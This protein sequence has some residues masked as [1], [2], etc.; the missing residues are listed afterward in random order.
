MGEWYKYQPTNPNHPCTNCQAG[1][2]SASSKIQDGE[3]WVK[4][5]NCYETC[6]LLKDWQKRQELELDIAERG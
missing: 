5:D 3:L 2:G 4:Y 1:S 6:L